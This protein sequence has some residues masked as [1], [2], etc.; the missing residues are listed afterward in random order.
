MLDPVVGC[1]WMYVVAHVTGS[2]DAHRCLRQ[3]VGGRIDVDLGK[4]DAISD[5]F[6]LQGMVSR[7]DSTRAFQVA[8]TDCRA[9]EAVEVWAAHFE[10]GAGSGL[11]K[12]T[13]AC[14]EEYLATAQQRRWQYSGGMPCGVVAIGLEPQHHQVDAAH[15]VAIHCL[16]VH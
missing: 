15:E 3:L 13:G 6:R 14:P 2:R 10:D 4:E 8:V 16:S 5:H 12:T 11:G 9:I 1:G 7:H